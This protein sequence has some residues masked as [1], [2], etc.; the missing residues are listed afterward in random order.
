MFKV[1]DKPTKHFTGFSS[2]EPGFHFGIDSIIFLKF[3]QYPPQSL[4]TLTFETFP[5]RGFKIKVYSN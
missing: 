5:R 3:S 2:T 1:I 4:M